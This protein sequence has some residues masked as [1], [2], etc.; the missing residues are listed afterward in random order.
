MTSR[1][2]RIAEH[3]AKVL[4]DSRRSESPSGFPCDRQLASHPGLYSWWGDEEARS[5]IGTQ[6]GTTIPSLVYAGQAGATR[7]PSGKIS[8]ATLASRIRGNHINGNASS[9]TFRLT[10][11]GLLLDPLSLTVLR[12]G[13]LAPDDNRVVSDW[14]KKHL[15]VAIVAYDDRDSLGR[16][17][18]AVLDMLD[19]PVNLEGRPNT[20][21][22][23]LLTSL[24]RRITSSD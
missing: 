3:L 13:R 14:I 17:E 15:E 1:D 16:I 2:V 22:R 8:T 11:S 21:P 10:L 7:W 12:P 19:P 5:M 24:R 18:A 9:S 4:T 6:L 20:P 23:R